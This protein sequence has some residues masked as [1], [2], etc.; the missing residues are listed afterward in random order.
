MLKR[1]FA[2]IICRSIEIAIG[3]CTLQIALHIA[4]MWH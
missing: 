2:H 3:L 4:N 1:A